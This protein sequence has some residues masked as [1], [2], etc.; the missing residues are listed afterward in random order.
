VEPVEARG[1]RREHE[2]RALREADGKGVEGA[3]M[4]M[5]KRREVDEDGRTQEQRIDNYVRNYSVRT[6]AEMLV[7]LEDAYVAKGRKR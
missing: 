3:G 1:L 6:L 2:K 5:K 7:E 4:T